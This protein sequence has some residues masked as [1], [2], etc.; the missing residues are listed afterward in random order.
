MN[1]IRDEEKKW[2]SGFL[3][4]VNHQVDANQEKIKMELT[5]EKQRTFFCFDNF[6]FALCSF[7]LYDQ[8]IL[9]IRP[10]RE[11]IFA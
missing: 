11:Y 5:I 8:F 10:E 1:E 9:Y 6:F 4:R 7:Y 3:Q 2:F